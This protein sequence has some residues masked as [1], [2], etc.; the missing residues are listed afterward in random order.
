MPHSF[1]PPIIVQPT[2]SSIHK[3]YQCLISNAASI[4]FNLGCGTLGLIY[5]TLLPTV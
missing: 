4:Q 2:Y 1:I 5:T 3:I